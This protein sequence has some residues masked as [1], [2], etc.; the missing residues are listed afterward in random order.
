MLSVLA[1]QYDPLGFLA[2]CFLRGK[3]ILQRVTTLGFTGDDVLPDDVLRDWRAWVASVKS[4][5]EYSVPRCCFPEVPAVVGESRI[6]Y[7]LHGFSDASNSGLSCV[8]YLRRVID[9]S[10]SCVGIVQ[11]K[12][13]G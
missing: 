7:Q 13:S 9:R 11:G 6:D 5:L 10:R 12:C 4:F 1:S 8:V 2:P 3:L